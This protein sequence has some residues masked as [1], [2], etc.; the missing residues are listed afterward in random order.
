MMWNPRSQFD[1]RDALGKF[2][3]LITEDR[4][5]A[6]E[7]WSR[8]LPL[9]LQPQGVRAY[10]VRTGQHA[11]HVAEQLPIHAAVV[12]M[13]TPRAE[14]AAG[15]GRTPLGRRGDH[16]EGLWLLQ[17][18]RRMPNRP[19]VVVVNSSS[20]S[21]SQRRLDRMMQQALELGAFSVL[22]HPVELEALLKV[23]RRLIDRKYQGHW[24]ATT[25]GGEPT[26]NEN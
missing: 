9:L 22:N 4:E 1:G 12:D 24:P 13:A 25:D 8:Q 15:G 18:L 3:V 19:P 20:V 2:N 16:P 11:L 7:H 6:G 23:I 5:H 21:Y 10:V 26:V 14:A 17:V